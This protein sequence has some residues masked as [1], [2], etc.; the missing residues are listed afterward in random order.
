MN[1]FEGVYYHLSSSFSFTRSSELSHILDING[2]IAAKSI[3]DRPV[4][5][6]ITSSNKFERWQDVAALEEAGE[7]SV[8]TVR[9]HF[10][11]IIE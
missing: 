3:D 7:I 4:T 1:L 5:H 9:I 2:A 10:L 11:C 8:V 6:F